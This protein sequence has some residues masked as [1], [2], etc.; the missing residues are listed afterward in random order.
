M[1]LLS[2][3]YN[4]IEI[5]KILSSIIKM[6]Q[7]FD[8]TYIS[9]YWKKR[10][11]Y[12]MHKRGT[13]SSSSL[14]SRIR[15]LPSSM[16]VILAFCSPPG[17]ADVGTPVTLAAIAPNP[18]TF[19]GICFFLSL[20]F[21]SDSCDIFFFFCPKKFNPSDVIRK[22]SIVFFIGIFFFLVIVFFLFV[23]SSDIV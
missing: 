17:T 9:N 7:N 23:C 4:L 11:V 3:Y 6:E 2:Y 21:F 15:F 20:F 1:A 14:E 16:L 10:K 13:I 5:N 18:A 8:Y 19:V 12:V 22:C